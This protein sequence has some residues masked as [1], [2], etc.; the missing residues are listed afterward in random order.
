[1]EKYSH[2]KFICSA[3]KRFSEL[4]L[5]IQLRTEKISEFELL[6]ISLIINKQDKLNLS[7]ELII[8]TVKKFFK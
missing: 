6:K 7:N 1:M 8:S 3:K 4:E 5:A 2:V